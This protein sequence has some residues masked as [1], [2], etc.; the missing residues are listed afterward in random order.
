M[1]GVAPCVEQFERVLYSPH[2]HFS[3][4]NATSLMVYINRCKDIVGN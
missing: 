4:N 2:G 3:T 1:N